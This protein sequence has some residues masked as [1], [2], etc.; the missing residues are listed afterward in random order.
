MQRSVAPAARL[1]EGGLAQEMQGNATVISPTGSSG[2]G[3]PRRTAR[4]RR[5]AIPL[6]LIGL[7]VGGPAGLV[8]RSALLKFAPREGR[9]FRIA[10]V[11]GNLVPEPEMGLVIRV[12]APRL[13]RTV[14]EALGWRAW[15]IPPRTIPRW[16]TLEGS[17]RVQLSDE[18]EPAWLPLVVRIRPDTPAPHLF[19]RLP[20]GMVNEAL[21]YEGSFAHREKTR[22]YALGH[23]N[24][25]LSLRFDTV[26][27]KSKLDPRELA[28]PVTFRRIEGHA[29]GQVRFKFE[30]NWFD[31]RTTA[32]VRRMDLRCDL[33]FQKYLDGLAMSYKIT[34]PKLDADIRNLAPMFEK[35]PVE[36]IRKALE[37]S[38]GRPRNLDRLA[39]RRLPL[40][41]PLDTELDIE[42]YQNDTKVDQD[43]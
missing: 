16:L 22:R 7:W 35:H 3:Q 15:L 2:A 12:S 39:R 10:S 18:V 41:L 6:V 5:R 27:L 4:W 42:V 26:S 28:R 21:Q 11:G 33:D 40:Y 24:T 23:Y 17:V 25:I 20:S 8:L 31:A 37:N 19:V 9:S 32:R 29:T 30:E 14:R 34:I 13:N 38:I 1:P 36:A 43:N